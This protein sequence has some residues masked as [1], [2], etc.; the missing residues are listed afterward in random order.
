MYRSLAV[1]A[2][3]IALTG[4][5]VDPERDA[6]RVKASLPEGCTI[7]DLGPYG[8]IESL[9]MIKCDGRDTVSTNTH[10]AQSDGRWLSKESNTVVFSIDD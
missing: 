1:L 6:E 8:E 3:V 2:I 5:K 9:I 7:F 10:D 4:C